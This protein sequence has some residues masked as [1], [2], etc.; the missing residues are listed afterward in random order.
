M[1]ISGNLVYNFRLTYI[2]Q[3]NVQMIQT[4][5]ALRTLAL[6]EY[7]NVGPL[8]LVHVL[9]LSATVELAKQVRINDGTPDS[10]KIILVII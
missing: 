5:Q 8:M 6:Q 3:P 4:V 9:R 10:I 7:A 2:K 1:I